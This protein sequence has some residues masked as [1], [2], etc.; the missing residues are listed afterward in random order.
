MLRKQQK[1]LDLLV[2]LVVVGSQLAS[3]EDCIIPPPTSTKA[4]RSY[5]RLSIHHSPANTT[6]CKHNKARHQC[7]HAPPT[8]Q[9]RSSSSSSSHVA[10]D[11]RDGT[12]IHIVSNRTDS[13][14]CLPV[15]SGTDDESTNAK[16]TRTMWWHWM[17][18]AICRTHGFPSAT[19]NLPPV[20]HSQRTT[21]YEIDPWLF[22]SCN[23]TAKVSHMLQRR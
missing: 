1:M 4:N 21:A 14:P 13:L 8:P 12:V 15:I 19:C 23:M 6:Q 3:N 9:A 18:V 16:A 22:D 10:H 2:V 17:G 7:N 20:W 11:A 5:P